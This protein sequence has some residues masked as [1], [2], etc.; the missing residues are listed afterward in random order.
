MNIKKFTFNPFQENTYV[1]YTD[2]KEAMIVDPGCSNA[3]EER[4]LMDFIE[5]EELKVSRLLCTH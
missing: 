2:S 1:L 3:T 5:S 4:E